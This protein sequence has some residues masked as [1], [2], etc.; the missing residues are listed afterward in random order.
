MKR[1]YLN[2]CLTMP[3]TSVTSK[4]DSQ[5]GSSFFSKCL[6]FDVDFKNGQTNGNMVLVFQIVAFDIV[7]ADSKYYKENTCHPEIMF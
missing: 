1:G 3:F 7:P 6:K 2:I 5:G 4:I